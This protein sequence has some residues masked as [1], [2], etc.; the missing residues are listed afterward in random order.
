MIPSNVM[1]MLLG[2]WTSF[3]SVFETFSSL[4]TFFS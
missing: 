1:T 3:N 2:L 4:F